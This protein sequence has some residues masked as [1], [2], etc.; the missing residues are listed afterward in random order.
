MRTGGERLRRA[1]LALALAEQTAGVRS[2][3][4]RA[5]ERADPSVGT[6]GIF[7]V[8]AGVG[9]LVRAAVRLAPPHAWTVFVGLPDVGWAAAQRAGIDLSRAVSVPEPG[10]RAAEVLGLLVEGFDVVCAGPMRLAYAERRALAARI[11]RRGCLLL[12]AT[13]WPG[14]SVRWSAPRTDVAN[15]SPAGLRVVG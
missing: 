5:V 11:R 8:G 3:G 13:A 2:V 10:T 14:L 6:G 9:R 12:T 1:R 15:A 4:E 7:E